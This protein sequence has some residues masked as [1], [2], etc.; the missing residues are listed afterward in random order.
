MRTEECYLRWIEKYIRFHKTADGFRHP[1][2]LGA[3]EVEQFL[4]DLAVRGHV[5]TA[6]QTQALCALVFLYREVL[7]LELGSRE[8]AAPAVRAACRSSCRA[9]KSSRSSTPSTGCRPR[10]PTA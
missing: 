3:A 5:S 1:A 10:S 7:G 2:T 6:T 8:A 4:T 9:P